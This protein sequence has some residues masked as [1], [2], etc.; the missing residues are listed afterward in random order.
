M[1][2]QQP[3]EMLTHT[4]SMPFTVQVAEYEQESKPNLSLVPAQVETTP[5]ARSWD[6]ET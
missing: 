2:V 1:P 3:C 6:T 5:E 4:P